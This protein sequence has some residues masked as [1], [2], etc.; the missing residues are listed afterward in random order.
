MLFNH[1][2]YVLFGRNV[3]LLNMLKAVKD[4]PELHLPSLAQ[5]HEYEAMLL[6]TSGT[7]SHRL[8]LGLGLAQL[9]RVCQF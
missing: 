9:R 4:V 2:Y 5:A 7:M 3:F 6:L 1:I 8:S